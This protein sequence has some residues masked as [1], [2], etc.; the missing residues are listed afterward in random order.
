M[1]KNQL[2]QTYKDSF[3]GVVNINYLELLIKYDS[4]AY[5]V[6]PCGGNNHCASRSLDTSSTTTDGLS[7]VLHCHENDMQ[8]MI[9]R[10]RNFHRHDIGAVR[11]ILLSE[12]AKYFKM[13]DN[14]EHKLPLLI[15]RYKSDKITPKILFELHTTHGYDP[16]IVESVVGDIPS[17]I[18][19]E[20]IKLMDDHRRKSKKY[21]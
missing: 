21:G 13:L 5:Y 3:N 12:E 16:S 10:K 15:K 17:S 7:C 1:D 9:T 19:D 6:C 18:H 14:A 4:H 20:Y 11:K 2:F 8:W